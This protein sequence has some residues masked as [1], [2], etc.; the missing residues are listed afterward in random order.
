GIAFTRDALYKTADGENWR[1]IVLPKSRNEII[2]AAFFN[3]D[4]SGTIILTE[5]KSFKLFVLKTFDG[6]ISW[7]KNLFNINDEN[8]FEADLENG[9]IESPNVEKI[10]LTF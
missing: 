1:E 9:Q 10:A 5:S 3:D 7:N 4:N 8:L 2:S 6:G